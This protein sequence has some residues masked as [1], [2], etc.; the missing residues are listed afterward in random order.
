MFNV[1]A[2]LMDDALEKRCCYRSRLV[3]NYCCFYNTY[4]SQGSAAKHL[5]CVVIFSD[6]TITNVILILTVK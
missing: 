1:S 3:F 4:I 6:N 2:L 5:R